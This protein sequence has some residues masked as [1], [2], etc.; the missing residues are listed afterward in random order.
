MNPEPLIKMLR[1]NDPVSHHVDRSFGEYV[2]K[3]DDGRMRCKFCRHL[4]GN[5]TSISRIKLHLAGV[6]GRGVK[7]CGQVPQ[8]VQDAALPAIDGRPGRKR[9]TVA[10]S[11]NNEVQRRNWIKIISGWTLLMTNLILEFASAVFD[12]LGYAPIGMV[13]AFVALLLATAELI[14]MAR[15]EIMDLLPCFHRPSTSTSAP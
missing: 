9:K 12:Q 2:E 3:M 7:I 10:G 6:T 14:Y 11:R 5:G 15:K 8:D 1:Q 13:L 4:F